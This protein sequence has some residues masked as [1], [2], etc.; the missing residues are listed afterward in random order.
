MHSAI[1]ILFQKEYLRGKGSLFL[2]ALPL[3]LL[4]GPSSQ[5][6]ANKGSSTVETSNGIPNVQDSLSQG[7]RVWKA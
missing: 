2:E 3:L 1:L 4:H 5:F 6:S 7:G